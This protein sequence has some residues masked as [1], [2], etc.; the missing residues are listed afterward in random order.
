MH[1][2]NSNR[3]SSYSA[4]ANRREAVYAFSTCWCGDAAYEKPAQEPPAAI[5]WSD[6]RILEDKIFRPIVARPTGN[7]GHTTAQKLALL[8]PPSITGSRLATMQP[9]AR[10]MSRH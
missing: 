8:S 2:L 10:P 3:R 9:D 6:L 4:V 7:R 5:A 1:S